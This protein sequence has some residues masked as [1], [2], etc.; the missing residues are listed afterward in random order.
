MSHA[1]RIQ[2][3][4]TTEPFRTRKAAQ[5]PEPEGRPRTHN[6]SVRHSR[7][8]DRRPPPYTQRHRTPPAPSPSVSENVTGERADGLRTSASTQ[9]SAPALSHE[10]RQSILSRAEQ[11]APG[12]RAAFL[13]RCAEDARRQGYSGRSAKT[14]A[15][16]ATL[17]PP[18]R[19]M[20]RPRR[21]SPIWP[22][23]P[24]VR[25]RHHSAKS[26]IQ[27]AAQEL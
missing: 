14:L 9:R 5:H 21:V 13:P 18:R 27:R 8:I 22:A 11:P 26:T 16:R 25:S 12:S 6:P 19:S 4:H 24:D 17:R 2:K 3:R 1:A 20:R 15:I 23:H 7:S 10:G